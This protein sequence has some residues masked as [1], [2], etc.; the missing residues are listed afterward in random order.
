MGWEEEGIPTKGTLGKLGI[1]WAAVKK[2][3]D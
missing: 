1:E 2:S 3:L